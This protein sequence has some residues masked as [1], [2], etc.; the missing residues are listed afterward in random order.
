M[1][2]ANIPRVRMILVIE[3]IYLQPK[4]YIDMLMWTFIIAEY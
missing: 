3:P 2:L 4:S 1:K